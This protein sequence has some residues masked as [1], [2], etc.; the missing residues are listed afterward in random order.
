MRFAVRWSRMPPRDVVLLGIG[1]TN[2]Y[3]VRMWRSRPIA[4]ARLT[5]ISNH[6]VATYSGMLPGVLADQYRRDEMEID[7][8]RLT[9]AAEA[10]LVVGEVSGL[11]LSRQEILI[12]AA[13]PIG[14]D[15]LSIGIGSVPSFD[16]VHVAD[17]S[18]I[19]AIK[20]MQTFIDRLDAVLDE[21]RRSGGDRPCRVAVVGGGAGGMEIA[22]C[23]PAHLRARFGADARCALTVVAA[24]D[25]LLPGSL[26]ATVARVTRILQA[27][28]ARV[29]TGRHVTRVDANG[30]VLDDG[31][32]LEADVVLWATGAAAPP[33]VARLGLPTGDRGF[34]LTAPTLRSTSGAPV[35][36][37]GDTGTIE[38]ESTPKAGVYA[39]RQ[40]PVL[41]ENLQR[42]L[43]DTALQE[44]TPQRGFLKL[45]NTGDGRAV[46]EWRGLS[47]EGAWAWRLKDFIDRRFIAGY[48]EV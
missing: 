27:R 38:G 16:G 9:G 32:Q 20:P 17:G 39:V 33:L 7:L 37:V 43:A 45:M 29:L 18:R 28:G 23:L 30:L 4:G 6:A 3:V 46:G 35:F 25:R 36:V 40:A 48:R 2:A 13:P 47:F 8:V 41:W 5:C 22:M 19:V 15:V 44:Y 24:G 26:D 10:R 14:F 12:D 21:A 11:D 42:E 34:L 1:H 31:A